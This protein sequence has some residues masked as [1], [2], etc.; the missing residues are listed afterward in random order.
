VDHAHIMVDAEN[1]KQPGNPGCLYIRR[2]D[3]KFSRYQINTNINNRYILFNTYNSAII[4]LDKQTYNKYKLAKKLITTL[5]LLR[6]N[7]KF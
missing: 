6:K 3:M 5:F 4:E 1:N 2:K 7:L